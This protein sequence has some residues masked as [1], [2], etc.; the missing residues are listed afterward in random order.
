MT[1]KPRINTI[2]HSL[3]AMAILSIL[4][5][6]KSHAQGAPR[7]LSVMEI[8]ER[9]KRAERK[10]WNDEVAERK[11]QKKLAKIGAQP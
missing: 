4:A 3:S 7:Q 9:D 11:A 8:A 2:G 6:S 1:A 10:R 5:A